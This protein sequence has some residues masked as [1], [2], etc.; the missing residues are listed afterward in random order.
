MRGAMSLPL[1][2]VALVFAAIAPLVAKALASMFERH[3]RERSKRV[4][5]R[6]QEPHGKS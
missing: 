1:W 3:S 4:L 6:R 2:V 5:A